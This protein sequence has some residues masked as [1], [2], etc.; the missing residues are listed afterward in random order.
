MRLLVRLAVST[1]LL[2]GLLPG[3]ASAAADG[4]RTAAEKT[5]PAQAAPAAT[6]PPQA[7]TV[8]PSSRGPTRI[9]FDD[10]MVQGQTNKL[11]AVYLYQRKAPPQPSLLS[12]RTSFREE[13][14]RDLLE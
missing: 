11:G 5:P 7:P 6:P 1:A 14:A 4:K 12:R 10:R 2:A 13:I 9:D 8:L 3:L